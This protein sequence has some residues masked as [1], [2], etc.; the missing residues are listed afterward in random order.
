MLTHDDEPATK[1][2]IIDDPQRDVDI[3]G[4]VFAA[5]RGTMPR[6]IGGQSKDRV[7]FAQRGTMPGLKTL[8]LQTL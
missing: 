4:L 6:V 1:K 2:N 7:S 8:E 5:Q 3:A